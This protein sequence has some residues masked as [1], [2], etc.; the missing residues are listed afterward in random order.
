ME[1]NSHTPIDASSSNITRRTWLKGLLASGVLTTTGSFSASAANADIEQV[2]AGSITHVKPD[3]AGVPPRTIYAVDELSSPY[4]TNDW[5]TTLLWRPLSENLW[6]H[7][8]AARVTESGLAITY[9]DEWQ[10]GDAPFS[11]GE[12]TDDF[13]EL[14]SSP[15]A[16]TSPIAPDLTVSHPH[17]GTDVPA[18]VADYGD[19][20]V[21]YRRSHGEASL[22]AT[23]TQG[24]PFVYFETTGGGI[25][26]A[27]EGDVSVWHEQNHVLGVSVDGHH[28]GL[29]A[30]PGATWDRVGDDA[31]SSQLDDEGYVS[32]AV[33]P[34]ATPDVL[35]AYRRRAYAF[36]TDTTVTWEY[37][38]ERSTVVTDYEF[39]LEAKH[40]RADETLTALYPH[41]AKRT[42]D[43][44]RDWSY[45]SPRGE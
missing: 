24:S 15:E 26:M 43:E 34:E 12:R 9:P 18:K 2:G 6:I 27:F 41:Q 37:D 3:A 44:L 4:P 21:T 30:P 8:L 42:T 10:V 38:S 45:V 31:M 25:D 1:D 32:I 23:L 35:N 16:S 14:V 29:F 28:Y 11:W 36:V 22:D 5:W 40:G 17:V 39:E 7:P 13:A 33:L 19:W 20:S